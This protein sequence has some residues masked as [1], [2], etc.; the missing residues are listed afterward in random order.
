[1]ATSGLTELGEGFVPFLNAET[2]TDLEGIDAD[3]AIIGMPHGVP[4]GDGSDAPCAAAPDAIR[5]ASARYGFDGMIDHYDYDFGGPVLDGQQI[6]VVDCGN[7]VS[8]PQD[9]S[10]TVQ[11]AAKATE[12]IVSSGVLPIMLGGDDSTPIP[13]FRGFQQ[14][15]PFTLVQFDAHIDWRDE[16]GGVTEGYSSTMRRASEM[17]W[18]SEIIQIGMRG[19]GSARQQEVDDAEA[20]GARIITA[21]E[22][23]ELGPEYVLDQ[24][25]PGGPYLITVDCDG[26]DPAVMPAVG[27]PVP[28]G[29]LF[30]DVVD[31]IRGIAERGM[32][33]GFDLV[34][35]QPA[36]DLNSIT[37]ITATRLLMNVIG[38]LVRSGQV[39]E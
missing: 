15:G 7:V 9:S 21:S 35:Y 32:I 31:L 14:W 39:G 12:A 11:R 17:G 28:G 18:I 6:G 30:R 22:A 23:Y 13:F 25:P 8:D 37:A 36:K 29:L 2:V 38:T 20:F 4:Y 5:R 27:A 16:V 10:G 33:S 34:E 19:V 26:F 1:M 24:I 3:I